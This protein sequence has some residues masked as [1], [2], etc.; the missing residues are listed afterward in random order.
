MASFVE[1]VDVDMWAGGRIWSGYSGFLVCS[2]QCTVASAVNLV[3]HWGYYPL[4]CLR[5]ECMLILVGC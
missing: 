3:G 1:V 2:K 5:S 4:R